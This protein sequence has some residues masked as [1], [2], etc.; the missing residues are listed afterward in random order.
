MQTVL[1]AGGAGF[2]G[3]ALCKSLLSDKYQV[4]CIDNLITGDVRN[5]Q[6]LQKD[7]NFKF[8]QKDISK[9]TSNSQLSILNSQ[10]IFHLASPA[11]P[12][13]KSRKSYINFPIETMLVNS[14]GTYNLLEI[15]KKNSARVLYASSSEI[16]GN[17]STSP[18]K[19]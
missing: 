13:A 7:S 5:I 14:L 16:Y 6:N 11:S 12:N 3:S 4:L 2:I 19:E 9:I 10:F 15:A 17:P 18:Q 8:I 1:V